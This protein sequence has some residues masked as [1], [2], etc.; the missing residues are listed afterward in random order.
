MT[1]PFRGLE[2]LEPRVLLS[3]SVLSP[4]SVDPDN[5]G[6]LKY[7]PS[8]IVQSLFIGQDPDLIYDADLD[9]EQYQ[10]HDHI[11]VQE[12]DIDQDLNLA[13]LVAPDDVDITGVPQWVSEGPIAIQNSGGL[14]PAQTNPSTG[15]VHAIAA[16]PNGR[17]V[18]VGGV[19][20][21]CGARTTSAPPAAVNPTQCGPLRPISFHRCQ[22]PR[23]R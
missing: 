20:G 5:D 7:E 17:H 23:S 6:Q 14:I 1:A 11:V 16:H 2:A 10:A 12:Q 21:G 4:L 15:A 8:A 22:S 18:W 9:V 3:N 19:N 13:T